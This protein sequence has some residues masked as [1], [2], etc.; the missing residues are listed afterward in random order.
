MIIANIA[1]MAIQN[2]IFEILLMY[3]RNKMMPMPKTGSHLGRKA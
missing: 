2:S 3:S 1:A